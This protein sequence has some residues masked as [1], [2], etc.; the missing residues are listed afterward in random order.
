MGDIYL[1][2]FKKVARQAFSAWNRDPASP[3]FGSFDRQ[4]WGWKK[5]DFSDATLQCGIKLALEFG[6]MIRQTSSFPRLVDGYINYCASIQLRDGS[7]NQCYPNERTPGVVYDILSTLVYVR[8]SEFLQSVASEKKLDGII[9]RA[10][11]FALRTDEKH[12]D[13]ANHL[14]GYA[15]ELLEYAQ[16]SKDER[17]RIKG[18]NYIG[19]LFDLLD[20]T[21]GWLQEYDGPDPGYQTRTLRYLV[22]CAKLLGDQEIWEVVEKGTAFI[23]EV[24]MPDGSLHPMLGS[25]STA[26]L[27]PSAFEVLAA[28]DAQYDDLAVLIRSAWSNGR[29]PLPSCLDFEN[30]SRLA[31]D[32]LDAVWANRRTGKVV[33][34]QKPS[35]DIREPDDVEM[36]RAGISIF[37]DKNRVVYISHR[38][39]GVVVIYGKNGRGVWE[40]VY[41]DS[42]YLLQTG[43]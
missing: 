5:K 20:P 10:V 40:L 39:G 14:S 23:R 17:A 13:I 33:A 38:L 24:L 27:Y 15:Y 28:R 21:E 16:Y 6:K 11:R 34:I 25:R 19:R 43:R 42:G 9:E 4:Y 37:R 32:A 2:E 1:S 8:T 35:L 7:F 3:S 30:A 22:K 18:K 36:P 12:G 31:E 29:V 26:L 41:E